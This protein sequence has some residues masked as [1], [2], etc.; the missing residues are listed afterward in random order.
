MSGLAALEARLA[1]DLAI[2]NHGGESIIPPATHPEG[3]VHEVVIVGGGQSGLGAAFGLIRERVPNILVIDENPAGFEGPWESYARMRTLRTPKHLLA[4]DWG[5]PSL[6]F[7]A[8]WEARHGGAGWEALDKIARGDWM[9]YLRWYRRVTAL[10]VR[11][12]TRLVRIEPI[13]DGLYRLHLAAGA[14]LLARKVVLATGIQ[15]GGEWHVPA[16]VRDALPASLYAHTSGAIDY[17]A[18][19]GRRIAIL[20]GGAS[21]FDNASFALDAGVA[22]VHVFMRRVAITRTNPIRFMERTGMLARFAALDDVAR[23][24]AIAHFFGLNQPP[25]N[26]MF[27]RAAAHPG[28]RLH[29]GSPWQRVEAMDGAARVTTPDGSDTFDFLVLSTGLVTDP[30]LRPELGELSAQIRCWRDLPLPGVERSAVVDAH[31]YLGPDFRL[32]AR[33]PGDRKTAAALRG[34][35]AFNFSAMANFGIAAAGLSGLPR[36]LSRLVNGVADQLFADRQD[37][38][39]AEYF[40]YDEPEFLGRWPREA[41]A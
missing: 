3:H 23:Y 16:M 18:L 17:A 27:D 35:F 6:S 32:L 13:A 30:A 26:D 39:L 28:F 10:P 14:P 24:R 5:I 38:V 21:A 29:L 9:D 11:N 25:T 31:P 20:G 4:I 34:I 12:D 15:G 2:L 1:H 40:A 22:E 19:A 7:R 37:E 33:D 41:A 36:G 8:W